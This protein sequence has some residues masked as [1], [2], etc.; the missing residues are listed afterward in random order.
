MRLKTTRGQRRRLIHSNRMQSQA[1]QS[2]QK[3]SRQPLKLLH[4]FRAKVSALTAGESTL[5]LARDI[6]RSTTSPTDNA[7]EAYACDIVAICDDATP[8][9]VLMRRKIDDAQSSRERGIIAEAYQR[10]R[11]I[12]SLNGATPRR[13]QIRGMLKAS[14]A[15]SISRERSADLEA[16]LAGPLNDALCREQALSWLTESDLRLRL[17]GRGFE[18][19]LELRSFAHSFTGA[20]G[21]ME[22]IQRSARINLRTTFC[23]TTDPVLSSAARNGAFCL[24]RFFPEDVIE[25]I[26]QP[27]YESCQRE[28]IR[29]DEQLKRAPANIQRLL[30]F[31]E[32]TLGTSVFEVYP[33]F[34]DELERYAAGGFVQ[35]PGALWDEY[36]SVAFS[37]KQELLDLT[38][39]YLADAPLRR[40]I[41]GAMRRTWFEKIDGVAVPTGVEVPDPGELSAAGDVAA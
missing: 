3:N 26:F 8:A 34:M 19:H 20:A 38:K 18:E 35:A 41:A 31:V 2:L 11:A 6:E 1:G 40:R 36:Q 29:N 27:I 23:P 17:Y 7:V 39:A 22:A 12:Y 4:R 10:L 24:M 37:S 28:Q 13:H 21:E 16:F 5:P 33:S 15:K 30:T 14:G 9:E 32:R 25:R